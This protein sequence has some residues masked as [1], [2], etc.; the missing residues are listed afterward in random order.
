MDERFRQA[1]LRA[2]AMGLRLTSGPPVVQRVNYFYLLLMYTFTVIAEG[3]IDRIENY[4]E[5]LS[6]LKA[7]L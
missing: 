3:N 6:K 7:F 2:T 4:L 5:R 1:S